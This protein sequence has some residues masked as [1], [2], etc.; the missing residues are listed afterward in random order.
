LE[1]ARSVLPGFGFCESTRPFFFRLEIFFVIFPT[2]QWALLI[3]AF[4]FFSFRLTTFGTLHFTTLAKSADAEW[5]AVIESTHATV[6]EQ[7]PDQPVNLEP[8]AA[9]P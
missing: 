1:P 7:S 6:P 3:F 9:A 8:E 4:A 5:S 2:R